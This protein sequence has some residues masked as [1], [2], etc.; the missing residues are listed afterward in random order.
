MDRRAA[1]VLVALCLGTVLVGTAAL[2]PRLLEKHAATSSTPVR[3]DAATVP[4]T[5]APGSR[6]C[7]QQVTLD[8][9]GEV[10]RLALLSVDRSGRLRVTAAAPGHRSDGSVALAPHAPGGEAALVDVPLT[11]PPSARIGEV[12]LATSGATVQLAGTAD[13]RALTRSTGTL[14]GTPQREAVS[15]TLLEARPRSSLA[16]VGQFADRAAALSPAGPWLFWTLL[17]LLALGVPALVA[18]ALYRALRDPS[19]ATPRA[20]P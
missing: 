18:A 9:D 14:D 16:R 13:P 2:L 19:A 4:L 11:P 15:L 3:R 20:R 7:V 10:A 6:L 17:P 5:L 8:T 12:C 1:T